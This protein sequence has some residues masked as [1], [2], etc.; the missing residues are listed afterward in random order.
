[1]SSDP[2]SVVPAGIRRRSTYFPEVESLRGL[3][4]ALVFVFH[5]DRALLFSVRT[6]DGAESP[7]ALLYVWAGHTGVTLFFVLSAFLLSLPF[8][9][10]AYGGRTVSRRQ[11]YERR[12]LRILPLY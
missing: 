5:A 10:E 8:L 7:L 12:A 6:R 1:V 11:F 2:T 9:D 4:I 3:A